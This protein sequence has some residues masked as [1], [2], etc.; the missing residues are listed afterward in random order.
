LQAVKRAFLRSFTREELWANTGNR[1]SFQKIFFSKDSIILWT[2]K[3][4]KRVR[5]KYERFMVDDAYANI[6]FVRLRSPEEAEVFLNS[7][8]SKFGMK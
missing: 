2:I 7:A 6:E 4:H 1:E 3:T 5:K 8:A